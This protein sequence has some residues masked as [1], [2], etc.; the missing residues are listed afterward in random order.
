MRRR[1]LLA[2]ATGLAGTAIPAPATRRG[3]R[4]NMRSCCRQHVSTP[5]RSPNPNSRD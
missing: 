2:G 1:T 5:S 4:S 3:K